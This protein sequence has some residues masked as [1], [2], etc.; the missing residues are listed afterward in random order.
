V[1][2]Y[3]PAS[4]REETVSSR[5]DMAGKLMGDSYREFSFSTAEI[6]SATPKGGRKPGKEGWHLIFKPIREVFDRGERGR[7]FT[8]VGRPSQLKKGT[9]LSGGE[10]GRVIRMKRS[11]R[12]ERGKGPGAG[13][14][15]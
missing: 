7:A 15:R 2:S 12:K 10:A 14:K 11:G 5:E 8:T 13:E 9:V 6:E 3:H 1:T 4:L